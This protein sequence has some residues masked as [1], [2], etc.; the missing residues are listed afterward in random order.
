MIKYIKFVIREFL[1]LENDYESL[2]SNQD[3]ILDQLKHL[4]QIE[5]QNQELILKGKEESYYDYLTLKNGL[6][7]LF[8]IGFIGSS[9]WLYNTDFFNNATLESIKSLG[10]LSKDLHVLDNEGI[11]EALGKLNKDSINLSHRELKLLWEIKN[12]LLK[13]GIDENKSLD[14]PLSD[15][16]EPKGEIKGGFTFGDFKDD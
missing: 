5:V 4:E 16:L 8:F 1:G 6:W 11:F 10:T 7:V 2:L 14:T 3:Q 9:F 12:L 15:F 13:K